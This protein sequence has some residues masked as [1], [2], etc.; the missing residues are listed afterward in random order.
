MS[1]G[2]AATAWSAGRL[3][4]AKGPPR[5]LFGR[6]YEDPRI[7]Q[8]AFAPGGRV[9]CIASAGCTAIHLSLDHEVVAVDIN[10]AQVDYAAGR[11]AGAPMAAGSAEKLMRVGRTLFPL[12][13]WHAARAAR[14]RRARRSGDAVRGVEA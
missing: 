2:V 7:E 3:D 14:V 6:M 13:G 8:A 4:G 11:I 5:V 1:D 12:A 9:F 10:P